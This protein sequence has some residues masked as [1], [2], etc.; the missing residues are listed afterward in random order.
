MVKIIR[1]L[2]LIFSVLLFTGCSFSQNSEEEKVSEV[3]NSM[4]SATY[5]LNIT[6]DVKL[7][8]IPY[9]IVDVD[10]LDQNERSNLKDYIKEDGDKVYIIEY[11][12]VDNR[13][14]KT[15]ISTQAS[16]GSEN[17]V[18]IKLI[19]KNDNEVNNVSKYSNWDD[20]KG[21]I[22]NKDYFI[23]KDKNDLKGIDISYNIDGQE[24]QGLGIEF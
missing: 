18:K 16:D 11:R 12:I 23:I 7:E 8:I 1:K 19:D 6:D 17:Y 2:L 20:E 21:I 13:D 22:Y 15:S 4:Y 24:G 14:K 5:S 10:K 9:D 3:D